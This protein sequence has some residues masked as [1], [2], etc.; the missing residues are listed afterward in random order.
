MSYLSLPSSRVTA[1][2]AGPVVHSSEAEA[3]SRTGGAL[4][5]AWLGQRWQDHSAE[6][7]GSRRYQPHHPHTS[8]NIFPVEQ[9]FQIM[10]KSAR[11]KYQIKQ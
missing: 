11:C 7:A 4:T 8:T 1:P 6:T 9:I 2:H 3:V 5:V 10:L